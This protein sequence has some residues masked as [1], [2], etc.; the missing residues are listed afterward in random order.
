MK[1]LRCD[2]CA[3]TDLTRLADRE[4]RCNHCKV[5]FHLA[6]E[7]APAPP[8]RPAPAPRPTPPPAK[9]ASTLKTIAWVVVCIALLVFAASLKAQRQARLRDQRR[10]QALQRDIARSL[11]ARMGNMRLNTNEI[12]GGRLAGSGTRLT[13]STSGQTA[14][15]GAEPSV[16]EPTP[17]KPSEYGSEAVVEEKIVKAEFV[18]A[19]PLP[20][21][22][23]NIY[24]VGIYRN[25]GEAAIDRPR[26]EATLWSDKKEKLAV[27]SGYGAFNNLLPGEEVPI[28][29]LVQKA[30]AYASVTYKVAPERVRF[31][32]TVRPKLAIEKPK[33]E[34]AQ[35][36]GY[37]LSGTVRNNDAADV[38]FVHIV[39][40]LLGED[41]HIVGMQD[42]F[43]A[44]RDL[45]AGDHSPFQLQIMS[46]SRPPKS[47]RLYQ[48][49]SL[50]KP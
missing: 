37:R 21:R 5:R 14:H 22:V 6:A 48:F 42:G 18:D 23:G 4:Y 27:G 33:L 8:P 41:R 2:Q 20:D 34:P 44:Q 35:F 24:F 3:S 49:A 19:V 31:G 11:E 29:I 50:A 28:K 9:P 17:S 47:F 13:G 39:A 45:P 30:P 25:T 26:V 40:L 1:T 15:S 32:S 46:T 36:G 38:R 16:P 12:T 7:D 43:A 10:Q